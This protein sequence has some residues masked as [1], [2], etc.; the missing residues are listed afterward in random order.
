M[1]S[2]ALVFRF[3]NANTADN[4]SVN[5]HLVRNPQRTIEI[6]VTNVHVIYALTSNTWMYWLTLFF[7]VSVSAWGTRTGNQNLT[8]SKTRGM[9]RSTYVE[10]TSSRYERC[11][12]DLPFK[13]R[14][15][16]KLAIATAS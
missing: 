9:K 16:I 13:S 14:I 6:G 4:F 10:G 3:D 11:I 7:L 8:I 12:S 2:A 5:Q 1:I 15:A